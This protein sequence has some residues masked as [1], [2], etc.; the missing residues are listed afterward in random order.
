MGLSFKNVLLI[1]AIIVIGYLV[2]DKFHKENVPGETIYVAGKPYE[3]IKRE[4][5]TIKII[6]RDT[7]TK[8]GEDIYHDTTIYVPVNQPIDTNL[9]LK[10]YFSKKIYKDT[11]LL[12]H[13]LG[14]VLINDTIYKNSIHTRKYLTEVSETYINDMTIVK[15][16]QKTQVYY[17]AGLALNKTSIFAHAN[18]SLLLKTK[19]DKIYQFGVGFMGLP[20]NTPI[21]PFVMGGF[22][23]KIK[24][25]KK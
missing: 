1:V 21:S 6:R 13:N 8:K 3:V 5:D 14:H 24:I 10:D 4:I 22:Y 16:A 23:T 2:W 7:I 11:L 19:K 18:T 25:K 17:G 20:N 15:E 12:S 9:I